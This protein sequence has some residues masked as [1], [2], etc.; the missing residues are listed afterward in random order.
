MVT[1]LLETKVLQEKIEPNL[2]NL[3]ALESQRKEV[4]GA[5]LIFNPHFD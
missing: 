4:C 1:S 3:V 2:G 5:S